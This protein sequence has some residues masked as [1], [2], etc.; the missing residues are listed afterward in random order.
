MSEAPI[1]R[2]DQQ[3]TRELGHRIAER[4]TEFFWIGVAL[5]V[6]GALAIFFPVVATLTVEIMIGWLLLL[7]GIVTAF[8]A[9]RLE[10]TGAFFGTVLVGLLELGIG[11]YL[12]THPAAGI[13]TL[14]VLLAALFLVEGAVQL[15]FAFEMRERQSWLWMLLS[16]MISIAVGLIIAAGLPAISLFA[17]GLVVGINFLSTGIAFIVMSRSVSEL[18]TRQP[19]P[20]GSSR[21]GS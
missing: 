11:L 7:V 14:T 21:S 17:L 16:G 5:A 20:T 19:P 4:K 6:V 1:P 3:L 9:F 8:S 12:L 10:G 13:V 2:Q 18:A 15:S